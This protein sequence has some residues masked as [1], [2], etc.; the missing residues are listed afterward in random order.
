MMAFRPK[1]KSGMNA[2]VSEAARPKAAG[3]DFQDVLTFPLYHGDMLIMHGT[4]IHRYYEVSERHPA[5][6]MSY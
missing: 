4:K 5:K 3:K 6:A 2:V 1:K